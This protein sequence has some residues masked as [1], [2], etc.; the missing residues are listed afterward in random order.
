MNE[1][2][3]NDRADDCGDPSCLPCRSRR[4]R[5]VALEADAAIEAEGT[6]DL[7]IEHAETDGDGD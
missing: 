4:G 1:N 6:G 7:T 2:A 3:D 5:D